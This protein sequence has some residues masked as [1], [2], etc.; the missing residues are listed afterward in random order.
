MKNIGIM[1]FLL[2]VIPAAALAA[3]LDGFVFKK[4]SAYDQKAVVKSP[5]GELVLVTIGDKVG[6]TA[7]IVEILEDGVVLEQ[8]G[9]YAPEKLI[10]RIENGRQKIDVMKREPVKTVFPSKNKP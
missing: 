8:P 7:T 6:K 10:V 9:K 1:I 2:I 5:Q 4:I 3:D